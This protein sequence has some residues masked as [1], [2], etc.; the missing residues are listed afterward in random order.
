MRLAV[1]GFLAALVA[2]QTFAGHQQ[3]LVYGLVLAAAYAIVMS[4]S[5]PDGAVAWSSSPSR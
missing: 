4:R 3:T 1:L 5:S 2:A